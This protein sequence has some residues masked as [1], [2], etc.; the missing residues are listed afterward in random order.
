MNMNIFVQ[1]VGFHHLMIF[2]ESTG[3]LV[4]LRG[5]GFR[6]DLETVYDPS[7]VICS[8]VKLVLVMDV[9]T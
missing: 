3:C 6:A 7:F 9:V 2:W 1:T 4:V 5:S 8:Q